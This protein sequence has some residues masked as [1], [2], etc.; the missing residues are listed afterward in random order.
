MRDSQVAKVTQ[1]S[2]DGRNDVMSGVG[3][4]TDD[5]D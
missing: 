5:E 2:F 4:R 3:R 1:H